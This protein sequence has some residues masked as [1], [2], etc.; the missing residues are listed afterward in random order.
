MTTSLTGGSRGYWV[1]RTYQGSWCQ[2]G[3]LTGAEMLGMMGQ[4][5]G[6]KRELWMHQSGLTGGPGLVDKTGAPVPQP[7]KAFGLHLGKAALLQPCLPTALQTLPWP[8]AALGSK[9]TVVVLFLGPN[10]TQPWLTFQDR[11][12]HTPLHVWTTFSSSMPSRVLCSPPRKLFLLLKL[13]LN[14]QRPQHNALPS[15]KSSLL[16]T[17]DTFSYMNYHV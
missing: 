8:P 17:V 16:A 11:C 6:P 9:A 13:L 15:W 3:A 7:C 5:Q 2:V 10:P 12:L 4:Q 14:L 1:P